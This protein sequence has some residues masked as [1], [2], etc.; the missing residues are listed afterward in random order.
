MTDV[1]GERVTK[2]TMAA[3]QVGKKGEGSRSIWALCSGH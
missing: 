3:F 2:K 1:E